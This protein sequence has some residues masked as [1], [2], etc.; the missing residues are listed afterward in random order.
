METKEKNINERSQSETV[1]TDNSPSAKGAIEIINYRHEHQRHFENLNR[2][3]IERFFWME[4][5][6]RY[7]LENPEEAI[8]A[9]GGA[10]L[11]ASYD[12]EIAGTVALKKISSDVYE[13][14]KMAVDERFRRRGI[15]EALSYAS[16]EKASE[17]GAK[18]VILYSNRILK[19]AIIMYHKLGFEEV[20]IEKDSGYERSDIKMEI[21]LP[22]RQVY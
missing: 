17:L 21:R 6:D 10:I 11:M 1:L 16:F 3:W 7:V 15:A 12:G 5:Q 2:A 14:T 18:K 20:E 22:F 9:K 8:I 13:F 4:E 19:P